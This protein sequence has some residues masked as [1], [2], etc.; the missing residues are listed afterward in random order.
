M[1]LAALAL[2]AAHAGS[3]PRE[4][5][6]YVYS[7]YH[8]EDFS[9][10]ERPEKFF[11][12]TLTAAIR[13]DSAGGE[14]GYLDGDPL[15]DCQD[16]DRVSAQVR[17]LVQQTPRSAV[18]DIRVTLSPKETRDLELKLI[19]TPGGW[20]ISDLVGTDHKSLLTELQRSNA[21]R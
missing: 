8:H 1:I 21:H 14:V 20:R 19:L 9:P 5:I 4:F 18:A 13:K 3:T 7:Q 12:P 2:A 6:A 10:L 17:K 15:C 16:Y 11:S